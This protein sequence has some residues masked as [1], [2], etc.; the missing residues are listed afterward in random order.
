MI[1]GGFGNI[2]MGVV[3][4]KNR[5]KRSHFLAQVSGWMLLPKTGFGLQRGNKNLRQRREKENVLCF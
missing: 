2:R 5:M 3:R 4:K 1:P